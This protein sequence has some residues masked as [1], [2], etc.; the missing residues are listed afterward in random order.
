MSKQNPVGIASSGNVF[1][2][3]GLPDADV[4]KVRTLAG[5]PHGRI[6]I[7]VGELTE[8]E[9]ELISKAT[10]AAENDYDHKDDAS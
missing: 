6:A 4:P 9:I 7:P 8:F 3:L 2:D 1:A 10:V 5:L